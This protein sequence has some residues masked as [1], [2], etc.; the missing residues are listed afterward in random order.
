[1]VLTNDQYYG[2]AKLERWYQKYNHQIIEISGVVGTGVWEIIQKFID[3]IGFDPRE[4]MY[5]SYDQKQVLE[6]AAKRYHAYY[7]NG[8][9]YNY[10]R[11]VDFDTIPVIN[12][13]ST[14]IDYIWKKNVRK[15]ID[16]RYKLII[17]FDSVLL[18]ESTLDDLCTF[19]L[20]IVLIRDPMLTPAPDTC[21]FL[22]DS[23]IELNEVN[24]ELIKNPIVYFAH[25]ILNGEK[26]NPGSYDRVSVVPRK[27]MN[28]YNI[29]SSNMTIT[30][31]ERMRK[32]I[33]RIY[34][35]KILK[36]KTPINIVGERMI[37]MDS[38]YGEKLVNEDEKN[39]KIYLTKGLVGNL[40]KCN[41]HAPV[42]KYVPIEFQP[43]FY[44]ESFTDLYMDRHYLNGVETPSRQQIPDDIIKLEYAY[45]L[46]A[47]TARLSHWDKI[48]MITEMNE[49]G[50]PE[51]Q[52]RVMYTGLTRAR[53]SVTLVI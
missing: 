43:E 49:F 6:M 36:I 31:T 21:T 53:E 5:L 39:I 13:R 18:N 35:D 24:P 41:K 23:N 28:L 33:N 4:I 52:K 9:I 11:I 16:P 1:M 42:T 50:D 8:I 10:T 20:P 38:I 7:I 17:V 44:H 3:D 14:Q 51:L 34:R 19:G 48:T 37:V 40:T 15:K 45:A 22:R 32:E 2:L 30:M 29:R 26:I 47:Y 25:R 27:Q 12:S 46:S